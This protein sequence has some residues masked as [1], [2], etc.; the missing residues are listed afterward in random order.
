MRKWVSFLLSAVVTAIAVLFIY[1][2]ASAV[3][4]GD[5]I[6]DANEAAR[7]DCGQFGPNVIEFRGAS[8]GTCTLSNYGTPP[9]GR[10]APC[11]VFFYKYTGTETNQVNVA[12]PLNL[13][14]VVNDAVKVHCSQGFDNLLPPSTTHSMTIQRS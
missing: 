9:Q 8:S 7:F 2:E 5:G 12:I 13:T 14:Q 3:A 11:T 4:N 10:T 1:T 6:C